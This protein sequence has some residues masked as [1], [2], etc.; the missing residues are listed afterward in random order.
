LRA[1]D[2]IQAFDGKPVDG[3]RELQRMVADTAVGRSVALKVWRDKANKGINIKIGNMDK[4]NGEAEADDKSEPGKAPKLGLKLRAL[5]ADEALARNL[6]RGVQVEEVEKGSPAEEGGIRAGD[7]IVEFEK[8]RVTSP[9][10]LARLAGKLK[11]GDAA[12]V[13]VNRGGRS[14]YLTLVLQ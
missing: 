7:I 9:G 10:E 11:A 4:F 1:G 6:D 3:V 2:V 14:L 12:V 13:R 8:A 5:T